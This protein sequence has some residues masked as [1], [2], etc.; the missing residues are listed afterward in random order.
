M[1]ASKYDELD[2]KIPYIRDFRTVSSRACFT[3]DQVVNC[4]SRIFNWLDWDL[5]VI[6]PENFT[7]A[8]LSFG[9]AFSDDAIPVGTEMPKFLKSLRMYTEM[10][11]DIAL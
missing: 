8:I 9:I 5:M 2:D 1:I 7:T 4:E 10:F 3:W 11:T 6:S